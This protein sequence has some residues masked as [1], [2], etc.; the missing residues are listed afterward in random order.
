MNDEDLFGPVILPQDGGKPQQMVILLHGL[1]ADGSDLISLSESFAPSLPHACFVAPNAPFP[2]DFGPIG[3]QWF[4]LQNTDITSMYEGVCNAAPILL[5]YIY[6]QID[7]Y[8][9]SEQDVSLIGFSQGTMMALHVALRMEG[10]IAGVLGYSGALID[11]GQLEVEISSRPDVCLIHGT[12][13]EVVP[14]V[15]MEKAE[16][17][18]AAQNVPARTHAR[19]YLGHGI[20]DDGISVGRSFLADIFGR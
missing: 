1:G 14:F 16:A 5:R 15:A 2:C 7:K 13:D 20:D 10:S 3:Y 9:L 11:D 8:G 6:G 19:P 12:D 17:T 4:S 18:L